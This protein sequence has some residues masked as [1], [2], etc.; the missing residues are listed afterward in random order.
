MNKPDL[1]LIPGLGCDERLWLSVAQHLPRGM[2]ITTSQPHMHPADHSIETMATR[3]LASHPG[4]LVLCG[5][6]MGGI[7]AME[8]LRQAP[9]RIAGLVLCGTN[10]RP[11]SEEMRALRESAI[12]MFEAG[13]FEDLIRANVSMAFHPDSAANPD[14][15]RAYLDMV[16]GAGGAQLARQ[17]RAITA[18][19]DARLHLPQCTCPVLVVCGDSD[20]L[21]PPECAQEI[22]DLIPHAQLQWV[23]RCGHMLTMERPQ[24]VGANISH[25]L[26]Q[27]YGLGKTNE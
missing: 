26:A 6:S 18:R 4:Q 25:W 20:Q 21:T 27:Q 13:D 16:L 10:A 24:A 3:L 23:S 11:E 8:A 5:A 1:V 19:P 12:E 9:D 17:N 2:Q 14:L 22:A 7:I 15:V